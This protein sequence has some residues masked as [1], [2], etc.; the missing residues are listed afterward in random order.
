MR[1]VTIDGG[2]RACIPEGDLA[3]IQP[4]SSCVSQLA[5]ASRLL[6][7]LDGI[8]TRLDIEG[9]LVYPSQM[10]EAVASCRIEGTRASFTDLLEFEARS[11]MYRQE[12]SDV[13]EISN[14]VTAMRRGFQ[15]LS[16]IPLSQRLLKEM[17]EQLLRG[18][19]GGGR[20]PGQY[21][22]LQVHIGLGPGSAAQYV[23]P[24]PQY[25]PE[26]MAAWEDYMH[27]E[28][29][30]DPLVKSA[31]LHAQFELI[32]PFFDGNGRLGRMLVS[33]YLA[34]SGALSHPVL[35]ISEWLEARRSEYYQSLRSI[36]ADGDWEPWLTLFIIAVRD[37]AAKR[38]AIVERQLNLHREYQEAIKSR[39]RSSAALA[40][41]D[42]IFE[43]V[44]VS[45]KLLAQDVGRTPQWALQTL[46][47]FEAVGLVREVS[48]RRR[49]RLYLCPELLNLLES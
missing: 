30:Q 28:T 11:S 21:R 3:T 44:M 8:T 20:D 17:H 5:E 32:H 31:I 15:R 25:V 39:T 12:P 16:E 2:I 40:A 6:G 45:S 10:R 7:K 27:A 38:I 14:Y 18:V 22:T 4:P 48:V 49:G 46:K 47:K 24:P 26:L 42:C 9:I 35:V 37:Q 19:R 29:E 23:P 33:L 36:S 34:H 43:R 1:F 13:R 41:L